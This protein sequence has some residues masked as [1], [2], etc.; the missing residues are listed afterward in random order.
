MLKTLTYLI[1]L[2]LLGAGIYFLIFKKNDNPFGNSEAGFTIKDTAAVGKIF[3][4]TNDGESITIER[5][6]DGWQL[7]GKYK[8][9]PSTVRMVMNTLVTQVPV[10]PVTK[11]AYENAVKTLA[12]D[13]VKVEIYD[14]NGKKTTVFYVGG[15]SANGTGTN[16]LLEGAKTPYIV[17]TPGFSGDLRPRYPTTIKEWRDRTVFNIPDEEIKSVSVLYETNP[18][19]SYVVS[20]DNNVFTVKGDPQITEHLEPLNTARAGRYM[21][22]FTNVN[23]EGYLNGLEDIDSLIRITKK[24]ATIDIETLHMGKQHADLYWMPINRRSK[25]RLMSNEDV[26]DDY[27]AD[28]MFAI[29]NNNKDTIQIQ[30]PSFNKILRKC[31]EFYQKD[32]VQVKP[33][34]TPNILINKR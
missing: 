22:Y 7:N 9:L 17:Q 12:T 8:A 23:C 2:A 33:Q 28:R 5:K 31:F 29:I 4:S 3:L 26:P 19:N 15:P 24:R 30:M 25:N 1:V 11:S 27:D 32:E 10:T 6:S 20:R 13:G 14:R 18:I 16:M 34:P 21:K